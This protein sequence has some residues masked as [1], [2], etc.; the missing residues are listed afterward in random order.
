MRYHSLGIDH[1]LPGYRGRV[2]VQTRLRSGER[3]E[4]YTDLAWTLGYS[5]MSDKTQFVWST[6]YVHPEAGRYVRMM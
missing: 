3:L 5:F 4:T 1:P 6:T 2:E